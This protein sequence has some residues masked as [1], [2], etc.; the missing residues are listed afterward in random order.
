MPSSIKGVP[1]RSVQSGRMGTRGTAKS[2]G[3]SP[4]ATA[5]DEV[6]ITNTAVHLG[7]IERTLA[8]IPVVNG[9]KV[10][11][12]REALAEGSYEISPEQIAN[13]LIEFEMML[14]SAEKSYESRH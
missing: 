5:S 9:A 2:G 3:H 8:Q 1:G 12:I 6:T 13:K 4:A 7:H 14:N 11:T 10:D